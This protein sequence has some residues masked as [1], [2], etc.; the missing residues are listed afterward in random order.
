MKESRFRKYLQK[1]RLKAQAIEVS[2]T[3]VKEFEKYLKA[4]R[5]TLDSVSV[6]ALKAYISLLIRDGQNSQDRLV[7]IARYCYIEKKNALFVYL[8]AV[9]GATN[10]LP[11]IGARLA[12][13]AGDEIRSKVYD[14]VAFP[15]IGSPQDDYPPLTKVILDRMERELPPATCREVLTWNYHGVPAAAFKDAKDRFEK[16][17]SVDDYLRGEHELL[18]KELER[19]MKEGRLWYEQEIT[20]EVVAFVKSNQE[21]STGVRRGDRIIKVKIPYAPKQFL[22]EKDPTMQSYYACHCQLVRTALRDG[23]PHISPMFCYCSA[24]FEKVHFDVVFGEPVEVE[25]LETRLNGDPCCRFAIRI[26]KGKQK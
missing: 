13:I 14:G 26:P 21:V 5:Q 4:R 23:K 8:A 18:V 9:L 7:A 17:A 22:D 10:V 11:D 25:V 19:C 2:V 1:R 16:S 3:A 15:P 6:T 12:A 24:G 20:P